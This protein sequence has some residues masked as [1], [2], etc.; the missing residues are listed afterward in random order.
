MQEDLFDFLPYHEFLLALSVALALPSLLFL[1]IN[2][3]LE[4][5]INIE[6]FYDVM[7]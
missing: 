4:K 7:F 3:A 1:E 5:N 6:Q 2:I